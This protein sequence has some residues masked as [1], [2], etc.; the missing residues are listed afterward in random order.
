MTLQIKVFYQMQ[1][2]RELNGVNLVGRNFF[3]SGWK[4]VELWDSNVSIEAQNMLH[5]SPSRRSYLARAPLTLQIKVLSKYLLSNALVEGIEICQ[6]VGANLLNFV[7]T[8]LFSRGA[9]MTL[10]I[11]DLLSECFFVEGIEMCQF[12]KA[13][14]WRVIGNLL[15]VIFFFFLFCRKVKTIF[16]SS[17]VKEIMRLSE[18]KRKESGR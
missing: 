2:L 13:E 8:I 3:K 5:C 14:N 17:N 4:F 7:W 10:Q 6:F 16:S 9:P 18:I 11:K 15:N 12:V 1:F